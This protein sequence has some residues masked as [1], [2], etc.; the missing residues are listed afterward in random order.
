MRDGAIRERAH[1]RSGGGGSKV[2]QQSR[3][4]TGRKY[5]SLLLVPPIDEFN[6][7]RIRRAAWV[8]HPIDI[9]LVGHRIR[10]KNSTKGKSQWLMET[11]KHNRLGQKQ[12]ADFSINNEILRS[13]SSKS[14]SSFFF[15]IP[16]QCFNKL[17][18]LFGFLHIQI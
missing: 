11:N 7:K 17:T 1:G 12:L 9:R 10:Q 16:K 14:Y 13:R 15:L 8:T 2:W 5:S 4:G 18:W 6:L 3:E